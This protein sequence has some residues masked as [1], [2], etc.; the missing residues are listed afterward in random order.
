MPEEP[1]PQKAALAFAPGDG[2]FTATHW[3]VVLKAG[4]TGQPGAAQALE[5]LWGAYWYPGYA[6][7]RSK[8]CGAGDAQDLTQ[9]FFASLLHRQS[10]ASVSQVGIRPVTL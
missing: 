6:W 5:K 2:K 8:G 4:Q 9:D 7:I 1:A 10:L 3:S